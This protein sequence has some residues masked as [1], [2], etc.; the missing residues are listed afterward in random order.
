MNKFE[1]MRRKAVFWILIICLIF[2][3]VIPVLFML[4]VIIIHDVIKVT[5]W[6][7]RTNKSKRSIYR[8]WLRKEIE[9]RVGKCRD[10][11][12]VLYI[13][14]PDGFNHGSYSFVKKG[15]I[16]N[17]SM[18]PA[19]VGSDNWRGFVRRIMVSERRYFSR[20]NIFTGLTAL[21]EGISILCM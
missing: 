7:L 18:V 1:I 13:S 6:I 16:C 20:K 19:Y 14:G 8:K 3:F 21:E 4:A 11:N 5:S 10:R 15:K 12:T 2:I 9:S 17:S